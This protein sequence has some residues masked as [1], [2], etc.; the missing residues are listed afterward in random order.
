MTPTHTPPPY[1]VLPVIN[2]EGITSA[3][4]TFSQSFLFEQ[5]P[6]A[7]PI[8]LPSWIPKPKFRKDQIPPRYFYIL[9]ILTDEWHR[10][11]HKFLAKQFNPNPK[12]PPPTHCLFKHD[13]VISPA[14][15]NTPHRRMIH[16]NHF[17]NHI[18][19]YMGKCDNL[20]TQEILWMGQRTPPPLTYTP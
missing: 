19:N 14:S 6:P 13:S 3:P 18:G 4:V 7:S 20:V 5:I 9:T 10:H 17:I 16:S 8:S 15:P 11:W 1:F 2:K 12:T